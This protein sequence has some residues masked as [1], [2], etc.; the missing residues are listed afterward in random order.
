MSFR[1]IAAL[2]AFAL[3]LTGCASAPQ[4]PVPMNPAALA[5]PAKV[6]VMMTALPKV[7]TEF[8]G[9]G[10]LLCLAAASVANSELTNHTKTLPY[11]DLPQLKEQVAAILK[12]KGS[13]SIVITDAIEINKLPDAKTSGPNIARQ[14]FSALGAKYG[15]DKLLVIAIS[16]IGFKRPYA[17][18]IPTGEPKAEVNG[19]SYLVNLSNNTFE[20]YAP[21]RVVKGTDKWDEPPKFPGLTNAYFQ[22]I[23]QLK[24]DVTKPLVK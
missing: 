8:P 1:S 2:S 24:D 18:Y 20:W 9:A 23:E 13:N 12:Q 21:L 6:G 14:D 5:A 10:C 3:L 19:V 22:A 15:I 11:E 17:S 7:D 4:L 16:D